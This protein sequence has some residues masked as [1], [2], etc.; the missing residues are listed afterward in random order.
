MGDDRR[1]DRGRF[2]VASVCRASQIM[3]LLADA[4]EFDILLLDTALP[5]NLD[6]YDIARAWRRA[7]PGR[8]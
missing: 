8:R 4:P 6:G 3:E 1:I 2:A 5:D 7:L